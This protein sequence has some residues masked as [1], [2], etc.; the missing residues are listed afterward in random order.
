MGRVRWT[1]PIGR[2]V[3][4]RDLHILLAVAQA[5]SMSKAAEDL[6]IS[7]PVVSKTITDLEHALGIRL[8]DRTARGVEPTRYGRALLNRSV[9]IFDELHSGLREIEFLSDP[10]L[11]ALSVGA[12]EPI[13]NGLVLAALGQ[14]VQCYPGIQ[15]HVRTGDTPTLFRDLRD[16]KIDLVISRMFRSA[17]DTDTIA[18]RLFDEH[19]FVVAGT[20][21]K[22]ARRRK[23]ALTDLT[24]EP[25]V[26]P[27]LDN[28]VGTLIQDSFRQAGLAL[29]KARVLSNSMTVRTG[30][31]SKGHLL[32][33]L[34]GSTLH[35]SV[36]PGTV[37]VL[38]VE[39]PLQAQPVEI[40]TLKSRSPN[41][42]TEIFVKH[43]RNVAEPL[44]R[45]S[46][47][48]PTVIH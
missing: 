18:D 43:L 8:F 34:P 26:M 16:R 20:R 29:P 5:G 40:V 24:E 31:V 6:A 1:D 10:T 14:L 2:R 12:T 23:I 36:P 37:K 11:G 33:M 47:R 25:W 42:V 46:R 48:V 41:P 44:R 39:L 9:V 22:W 32:T 38:P 27:E 4:L 35:F 28:A 30:L 19:L 15:F 13:M 7:H 3:K 17:D 45:V 21:S